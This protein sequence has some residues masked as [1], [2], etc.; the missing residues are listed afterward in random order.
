MRDPV[1]ITRLHSGGLITN[2]YCSS[3][4]RHCLYACSPRWKKDYMDRGTAVKTLSKVKSMGCSS[5]H[6]GGGEPFLNPKGL[7]AVA[8]AAASAGVD[9]EYVETNSS[10]Y[11]DRDSAV[12][13]LR[14][15]RERGVPALLVSLSPFHNE[16][17]PLWKV[18]GVIDACRM[19]GVRVIP[20]IEAFYPEISALEP[21]TTHRLEEYQEVY[22]EDYVARIPSRYW[23]HFGGRALKSYAGLLGRRP[24]K[25]ILQASSGGCVELLDTTHFHVDLYGN[26]VPGLCSGLALKAEH[27][28]RPITGETY[29]FLAALLKDGPAG[30]L[31]LA[32]DHFGFRS[33]TEYASK[34]ELCLDIRCYLVLEKGVRS[35]D[36]QPV[37][38]YENL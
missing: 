25:Q 33:S 38:F 5:V 4:C 19:A 20:W 1:A 10:W 17:I 3:R 21:R 24:L 35:A 26:Y 37:Q 6:I 27:L 15:L 31:D 14:R 30:L 32:R 9:I 22:G 29:P 7:E 16:Y 28:G 11:R 2:Y 18:N 13:T 12:E 36:L 8:E 34:C 23:V